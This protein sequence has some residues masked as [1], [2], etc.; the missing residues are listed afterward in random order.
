MRRTPVLPMLLAALLL[1]GCGG[2]SPS[3][4][5]APENPAPAPSKAETVSQAASPTQHAQVPPAAPATQ[6]AAPATPAKPIVAGQ[7]A[8]A[9]DLSAPF[10]MAGFELHLSF[11]GSQFA[12]APAQKTEALA[13]FL[14]QD[15]P[16]LPGRYKIICAKIPSVKAEGRLAVV[17]FTWAKRPLQLGDITVDNVMIVDMDSRPA[18]ESVKVELSVLD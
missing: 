10:D 5:P 16:D 17:P 18:P 8:L 1:A 3:P 9:L 6:P 15:N 2:S 13:G 12:A 4:A 7:S 14:C 11:D